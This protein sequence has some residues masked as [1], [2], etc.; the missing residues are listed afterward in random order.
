M[1]D[2]TAF[3]LIVNH[4]SL[5]LER[6]PENK[7][8]LRLSVPVPKNRGAQQE[9]RA[10]FKSGAVGTRAWTVVSAQAREV[11]QWVER[12]AINNFAVGERHVMRFLTKV[13]TLRVISPDAID[14]GRDSRRARDTFNG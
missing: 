8:R 10:F 6:L 9:L 13:D 3:A 11:V 4:G 14:G 1:D 12:Y 7:L 5:F 2:K